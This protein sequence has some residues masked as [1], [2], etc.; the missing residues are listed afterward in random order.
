MHVLRAHAIKRYGNVAWSH[1]SATTKHGEHEQAKYKTKT[2]IQVRD[3][4]TRQPNMLVS[5][6]KMT[7][8]DTHINLSTCDMRA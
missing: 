6:F 8:N 7:W 3:K 2:Y 1:V 4:G 5:S